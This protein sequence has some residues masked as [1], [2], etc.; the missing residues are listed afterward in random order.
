MLLGC[1]RLHGSLGGG[2]KPYAKEMNLCFPGECA[3]IMIREMIRLSICSTLLSMQERYHPCKKVKDRL[4]QDKPDEK[5]RRNKIID[6]T[7]R[8]QPQDQKHQ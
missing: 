7:D 8:Q 4:A 5:D 6:S 2:H 3:L 1:E